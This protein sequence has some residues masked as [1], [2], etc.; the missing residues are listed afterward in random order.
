[1]KKILLSFTL[2]SLLSVVLFAQVDEEKTVHFNVVNYRGSDLAVKLRMYTTDAN[3]NTDMNFCWDI[4]YTPGQN[5]SQ[6]AILI[7]D[8]DSTDKFHG[9]LTTNAQTDTSAVKYCFFV[10]GSPTDSI[11]RTV[12]YSQYSPAARELESISFA[13]V[14]SIDNVENIDIKVYPNP[15]NGIITVGYQLNNNAAFVVSDMIG[16]QVYVSKLQ[17][18]FNSKVIDLNNLNEGIYFYSILVDGKVL[19]SDKIV[20]KN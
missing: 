2:F 5:I 13:P 11:C 17:S 9:Y 15:S 8:G 19:K 12:H 3:P 1:M 18:G 4:C 10:N 7:A 20:I 6:A 14:A 16:K